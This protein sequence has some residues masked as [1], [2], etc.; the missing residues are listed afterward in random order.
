MPQSDVAE[1]AKI[2]KLPLNADGFFQEAH[3]KLRPVEF[4]TEGIFMAGLAHYPKPLDEV[5]AQAQAVTARAA[6]VLATR[7]KALDAIKAH[8][9]LENCD[10]CAL[11][12]D[13]CPFE[14][15]RWNENPQKAKRTLEGTRL[16]AVNTALCKGCGICEATCPKDGIRVAGFS[17]HHLARQVRAL[18]RPEESVTASWGT[19]TA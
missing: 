10:G 4:L 12:L 14:A 15:I 2:Y 18:L 19:E 8:V 3:A 7:R 9:I 6:A 5:I 13:V 17:M 1:L 16:P 11:C